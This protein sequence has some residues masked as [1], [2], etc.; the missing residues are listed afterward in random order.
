MQ[1]V[2][3]PPDVYNNVQNINEGIIICITR[4]IYTLLV[5]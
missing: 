2:R 4:I 1:C 3:I 5:E